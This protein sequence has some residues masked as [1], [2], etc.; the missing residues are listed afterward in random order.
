MIQ[1]I[2]LL[3]ECRYLL[4]S[5][6]LSRLDGNPASHGLQQ[7]FKQHFGCGI[8]D[9]CAPGR[10]EVQKQ[11][12]RFSP[13]SHCW[14]RPDHKGMSTKWVQPESQLFEQLQRFLQPDGLLGGKL[15]SFWNQQDLARQL[16]RGRLSVKSLKKHTLVGRM[17]I[18][19]DQTIR[20]FTE[21]ITVV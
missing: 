15:H 5:Q 1:A 6:P 18:N 12:E 17:L 11:R 8:T 9:S 19:Q 10:H 3:Q 14:R 4:S 13:Q 7:V 2:E 21:N 16:T 20:G